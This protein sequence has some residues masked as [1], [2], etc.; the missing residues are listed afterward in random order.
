MKTLL[1]FLP[2]ITVHAAVLT[3]PGTHATVQSAVNAAKTGDTIN[4]A[5]GVY[6]EE[7]STK[8]S[9]AGVT[10][11]G[12][13]AAVHR[14]ILVKPGWT[15]RGLSV[16]GWVQNRNWSTLIEVMPGAHATTL[17]KVTVDG[18]GTHTTDGIRWNS[19]GVGP[20]RFPSAMASD[21]RLVD[22]EIT[23]ITGYTCLML[24]GSRNTVTGGYFH[25][26]VQSDFIRLFGEGNVISRCR[27]HRN[28]FGTNIGFHA[29][30]IQTFGLSQGSRGHVIEHCDI[31]DIE[32][33]I[34]QLEQNGI[35]EITGW[36]FRRNVFAN[37]TLGASITQT[38]T[39]WEHNVFY[40][41]VTD[42]GHV[43]NFGNGPRGSSD[44]QKI[45]GNVFLDCG[46]PT[47]VESGWYGD[48]TV[49][50]VNY[51][52]VTFTANHNYYG[53][54]PGFLPARLDSASARFRWSEKDG[55]NGGDPG[56][57]DLAGLN[58]SLTKNSRLI[59]KGP[60]GAD[61]GAFP[62]LPAVEPPPIPPPADPVV[63]EASSDGGATWQPVAELHEG[64]SRQFRIK[65][66]P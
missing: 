2:A 24:A 43:L 27:F 20:D 8:A 26:V 47:S 5:A 63:L 31:R 61:I 21:C 53:K 16:R 64:L 7:V 62:F 17:E 13:G 22:C 59:G 33:Q 44:G 29:D 18:V 15:I 42:G 54:G 51:R 39:V 58:F 45:E 6:A 25:D 55:V 9:Q 30:F 48:G 12:T 3:V 1:F 40:R 32:G 60:G 49:D 38:G 50:L 41:C 34:T 66:R 37:T 57:V 65:P 14:L 4:I 56:F 10:L 46:K 11:E 52:P 35:A 23:N 19:D 28:K 36:T